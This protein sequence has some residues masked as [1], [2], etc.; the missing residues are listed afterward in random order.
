M[1]KMSLNKKIVAV[2]AS[3]F[4]LI[5]GIIFL[6]IIN[7]VAAMGERIKN[8]VYEIAMDGFKRE[9][10]STTQIALSLISAINERDD[11]DEAAKVTLI[12]DLTGALRYGDDGYFYAYRKGTGI[13]VVHGATPSNVGRDLWG[14]QSPDGEQYIIRDL[15]RAAS[16]GSLYVDYYWSK[17][18]AG[19]DEL[20]EKIGTA[21]E[22]PDTDIWVGTGAYKDDINDYILGIEENLNSYISSFT[23]TILI[24]FLFGAVIIMLVTYLRIRSTV[25]ALIKLAVFLAETEGRNFSK[26]F[27]V[28][29][30]KR[31]TD[32]VDLLGYGVNEIMEK[33]SQFM[34]E[35]KVKTGELFQMDSGLRKAIMD[36]GQEIRAIK[37][38]TGESKEQ[39]QLHG[40]SLETAE[41]VL[42]TLSSNLQILDESIEKQENSIQSSSS[43]TEQIARGVDSMTEKLGGAVKD[44]Q[45]ITD[46]TE[47]GRSTIS[48]VSSLIGEVV[49]NSKKL[50]AA[51]SIIANLASKTNLLS[52]NAA[53]EAA[54]AGDAGRGFSVV[55]EEI[56]NLAELSSK[57]SLSVKENLKLISGSIGEVSEAAAFSEKE[58]GGISRSVSHVNHM[59]RALEN[60][61]SELNRGSEEIR[62]ELKSLS[63]QSEV[64]LNESRS[65][66]KEKEEM[67]MVFDRFRYAGTKV[68]DDMEK[69][70][71]RITQMGAAIHTIE[72]ISRSNMDKLD[73]LKSKA[74][75][76]KTRGDGNPHP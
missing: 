9:L 7:S 49:E 34:D 76:F 62:G 72:G 74:V 67:K 41:A 16:E 10:R 5:S 13:N 23:R 37:E 71:G 31:F 14:L 64:L 48:R 11:L 50:Q 12:R 15:D 21:L 8:D 61:M 54:H 22:V 2:I 40:K 4:V 19:T 45:E 18:N 42:N 68:N 33:V 51:N 47:Q 52:M 59:V 35:V 44:V 29:K 58:F 6:Q 17:P 60:E 39:A 26:T 55:A 46:K 36:S 73:E 70:H 3:S 56:R 25:K 32:E 38:I 66:G 75:E 43:A 30:E 28:D 20:F 57:Q 27:T 69:I 53:I 65:I 63:G 24:I 1:K